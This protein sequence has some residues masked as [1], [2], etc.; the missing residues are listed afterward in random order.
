MLFITI[1]SLSLRRR[2]LIYSTIYA[3]GC[4]CVLDYEKQCRKHPNSMIAKANKTEI[5]CEK[6]RMLKIYVF[7]KYDGITIPSYL[8][9][10]Q[11]LPI[12][13]MS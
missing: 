7:T 9:F 5:E 10:P 8:S 3:F 2:Y 12:G 1:L 6:Y 4:V 11:S 13:Y